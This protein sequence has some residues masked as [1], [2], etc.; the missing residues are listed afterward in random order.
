[1]YPGVTGLESLLYYS[2]HISL[3]S[4]KMF[5]CTRIYVHFYIYIL[6]EIHFSDY[7]CVLGLISKLEAHANCIAPK[8]YF[9]DV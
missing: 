6:I 3:E 7:F 1:V 5:K 8:I 9:T 2:L 4:H